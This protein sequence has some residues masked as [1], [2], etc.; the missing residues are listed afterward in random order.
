VHV[1][2]IRAKL[3][4][5]PEPIRSVRRPRLEALLAEEI[6][7]HPAVVVAATAGAGKTTAVAAAAQL[8]DR[9]LA[10]LTLDHTDV[11]PGRLVGYLEAALAACLPRLERV[12]GAALAARIPHAEAAGLLA[13]AIGDDRV[14]LVLDEL[15]RLEESPD[16]WAV[17]E[18]VLRYASDGLRVV[19]ISRRP[20]PLAPRRPHE[21]SAVPETALAFTPAEAAEALAVTGASDIDATA[22][23][24]ATGGW[25]TGVLFEAWR[26]SGHV[27]GTGGEADP[28]HGYLSAHI[29]ELLAPRD[30][31]FLV[32]T[33]V[34]DEVTAPRAAALGHRDAAARLAALR[35]QHLP[36]VWRDDGRVLRCH[37]RFREYL[38][39]LLERRGVEEVAA[40]R[41]AHGHVLADEGRLEEAIEELLAAGAPEEALPLAERAIFAVLDR[42]DFAVA[43]RWIRS[44]RD[45]VAEGRSPLVVAELMLALSVEDFHRGA[46]LGD[47][48]AGRGLRGTVAPAAALMMVLCY[49]HV[50]R[51]DAMRALV[52]ETDTHAE[53]DVLRYFLTIYSS[54]PPPPRP[55]L[56]GGPLDAFVLSI[57]YSYGRFAELAAGDPGGWVRARSQPWTIAALSNIGHTR[58]A[59]A[60]YET[61]RTRAVT[62]GLLDTS[63]GPQILVDAGRRDAALAA[64]ERGRQ[65]AAAGGAVVYEELADV[66]EARLAL[67]LDRDPE[68]ARAALDRL[69]GRPTS[70]YVAELVD[71]WYGYA[72]LLQEADDAALAR[73]RRAVAS[74]VRSERMHELPTAAVYLAEA[75]WRAGDEDAADRA[76]DIA[77][78]AAGRQG[79]NHMLLLALAD[80]PAVVARRLDAERAADS[81]WHELGRSLIAQG[82]PLGAPVPSSTLLIEFGRCGLLVDGSEQRP[83]IA[84]SYEL[85][86][87]LASRRPPWQAERDE[88]LDALFDGRNDD[89]ARAYLRQAVRW[90]RHVLTDD[91]VTVHD[92]Q[93]R[94]AGGEAIATESTRL[95][96]GLAEAARLR[97]ER[98]R[99]ATLLALE[100]FDRGEYLPG[101]RSHWAEERRRRLTELATD[102]RYEAA[103]LAFAAGR[104]EQ[105]RTLAEEVL[106]ADRSRETAWRLTM[107]LLSGL[108]DEDGVLRTYQECERALA[109][110]GAVP[111]ATT[112]QLLMSLRR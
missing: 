80:F 66:S 106:R 34:L 73:L 112:R 102:A 111:S 78:A 59:L 85:L 46:A 37:P 99:T 23:V 55:R 77:L 104:I 18:A 62:S 27:A 1:E 97:G 68:A 22:A 33:S 63:V 44:I 32:A 90:L 5:P 24:A 38:L 50:G 107:R 4:P 12:A 57:D 10:W 64:I 89:A 31:A 96:A 30:R 91:R 26:S 43:D 14:L 70:N 76:A 69:K 54:E 3:R 56:T 9:E 100:L 87:Y 79:S 36:A 110:I 6:E 109:E 8:L 81:P 61:A 82:V 83:R 25:V 28:L 47:E 105:A 93:V 65:A 51:F 19:L 95:E 16:A 20:L 40:K 52:A 75:E 39:E 84:K 58:E 13:E 7:R 94:V 92:G 21:L 67:R 88:L 29:V 2:V 101:V 86:A 71:T 42:L 53:A 49:A 60:H 11:A 103:E 74:M 45:V 72:L 108:G 98:R 17:I 48:L 41:L 35:A 15:E